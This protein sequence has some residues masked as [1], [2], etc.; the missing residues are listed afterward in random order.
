M[1]HGQ[2]N[3]KLKKVLN[4]M[5]NRRSFMKFSEEQNKTMK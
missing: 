2:R 1:M 4:Y 5:I 3:I